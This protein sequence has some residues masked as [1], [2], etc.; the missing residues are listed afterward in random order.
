MLAKCRSSDVAGFGIVGRICMIERTDE[1]RMKASM[2][3]T[4]LQMQVASFCD[5]FRCL[6]S[7]SL[8]L[9]DHVL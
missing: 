3:Q 4:T 1:A 8:D 7:A 9:T 2:I 5:T 6:I